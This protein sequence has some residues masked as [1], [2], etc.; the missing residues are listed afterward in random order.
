MN[1]LWTALVELSSVILHMIVL[2]KY[3]DMEYTVIR[4]F[5]SQW[6]IYTKAGLQSYVHGLQ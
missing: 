5:Q 4:V 1:Y 3:A 2:V 6:P